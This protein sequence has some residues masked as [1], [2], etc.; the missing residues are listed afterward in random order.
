MYVHGQFTYALKIIIKI[1][2]FAS[3]GTCSIV[4]NPDVMIIRILVTNE[5]TLSKI[6]FTWQRQ[7]NYR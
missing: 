7:Y 5:Q 3:L 2:M 4:N 1:K 6:V